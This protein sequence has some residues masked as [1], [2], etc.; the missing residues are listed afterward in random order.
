MSIKLVLNDKNDLLLNN[1]VEMTSILRDVDD[2]LINETNNLKR[3]CC[4]PIEDEE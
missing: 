4:I 3:A 1:C 2:W